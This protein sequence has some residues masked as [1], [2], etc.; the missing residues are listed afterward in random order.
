MVLVSDIFS[1]AIVQGRDGQG[2]NLGATGSGTH[3]L[4]LMA[5]DTANASRPLSADENPGAPMIYVMACIRR[6]GLAA[7]RCGHIQQR[8]K[9]TSGL[10][11]SI[12]RRYMSHQPG[13]LNHVAGTVLQ[14]G[15][16][17]PAVP[18]DAPQA[19]PDNEP[20]AGKQDG[21][22]Q[23]QMVANARKER[24][25]PV[26]PRPAAAVLVRKKDPRVGA[27]GHVHH[28]AVEAV[29]V[30]LWRVGVGLGE[31]RVVLLPHGRQEPLAA[32][33]HDGDERQ[34]PV[35]VV[36]QQRQCQAVPEGVVRARA[37]DVVAEGAATAVGDPGGVVEE[38]GE[39]GFAALEV[40]S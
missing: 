16:T 9:W 29:F 18:S 20:N 7:V 8:P 28:D 2:D 22:E 39:V 26:V 30:L 37:E 4:H 35:P 40:K 11:P 31:Q 38:R 24:I 21:K 5:C 33:V 3:R 14:P 10:I 15:V 6:P 25:V 17:V 36:R 12:P 23:E 34:R 1:S 19:E 13:P 27:G 32:R